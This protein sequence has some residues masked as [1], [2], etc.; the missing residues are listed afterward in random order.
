[1]DAVSAWYS[2]IKKCGSLPGY[3]WGN[4]ADVWNFTTMI[5]NG[6]QEIGCHANRFNVYACRYKSSD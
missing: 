5:W 1:M 4:T 6:D 3:R 2:E